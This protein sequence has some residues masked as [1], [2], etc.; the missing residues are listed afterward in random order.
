MHNG[1]WPPNV[2][3]I[4]T[5]LL[6]PFLVGIANVGGIGGGIVKM[7]LLVLMLNYT[8]KEAT[9][10]SYCLLFGGCLSNSLLLLFKKHPTKS[11]P[12]IDYNITLIINPSVLLGTNIGIF[13]NVVLRELAAGLLFIIF[14]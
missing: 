10:L 3:D 4:I 14:F 7:P 6:I 11:I 13:L 9:F 12:I 1:L 2:V 5:Y 8:P